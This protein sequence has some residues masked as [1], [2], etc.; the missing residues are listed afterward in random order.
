MTGHGMGTLKIRIVIKM[1]IIIQKI[2]RWISL[3]SYIM[4]TIKNLLMDQLD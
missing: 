3:A 4:L 2:E 1:K